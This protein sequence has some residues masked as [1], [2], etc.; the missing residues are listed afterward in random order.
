MDDDNLTGCSASR[1]YAAGKVRRWHA[2]PALAHVE[3]TIADHVG[4]CIRLLLMLHPLPPFR[5][6]RAVAHH[7]DGERWVGDLPYDFKRAHPAEASAHATAESA[8]LAGVLGYDPF[9]TLLPAEMLWLKLVDRLEAYAHV[10][11]RHPAELQRNGWPSARADLLRM[12]SVLHVDGLVEAV[13][14]VIEDMERGAW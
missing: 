3:Q 7:D 12:A 10:A 9:D 4:G 6:I 1:I 5:L 13:T 2:N 11:M 8:A 14:R